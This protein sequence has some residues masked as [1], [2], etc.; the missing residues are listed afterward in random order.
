[1]IKK[2]PIS[3]MCTLIHER[4][5]GLNI[6]FSTMLYRSD[7]ETFCSRNTLNSDYAGSVLYKTTLCMN[8]LVLDVMI[9]SWNI[10][11]ILCYTAE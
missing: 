8:R 9:Y 7:K 1:M 10:L 5:S 4:Q 3:S 2:N 11:Y 6:Q